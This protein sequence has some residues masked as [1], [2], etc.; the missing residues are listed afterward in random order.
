MSS[1]TWEG[2]PIAK[3]N[4]FHGEFSVD[5][6][7]RPEDLPQDVH[8]A[9]R[10][11]VFPLKR[12][13]F[14]NTELWGPGKPDLYLNRCYGNDWRE[15]VSVWNHDYN[16]YHLPGFY[17]TKTTLSLQEYNGIVN[18]AGLVPPVAGACSEE[19]YK[20]FCDTC[21]DGFYERYSKYRFQRTWRN[22]R[23]AAEWREQQQH[24]GD[25]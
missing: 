15:S 10:E 8:F 11:E 16:W 3:L 18:K 5:V 25:T 14:H 19:T 13:K 12:Y 21:G 20:I 9:S 1:T 2:H 17:P 7:P 6:F 24:Q 23:A 4:F 22:N